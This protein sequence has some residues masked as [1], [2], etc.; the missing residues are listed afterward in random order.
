MEIEIQA[1]ICKYV[2]TNS[3]KHT[4]LLTDVPLG[5]GLSRGWNIHYLLHIFLCGLK[6]LLVSF[7]N[8]KKLYV[9]ENVDNKHSLGFALRIQGYH[10]LQLQSP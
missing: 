1:Q 9:Y 2:V 10:R 4:H 8:D 5:S 6:S 3:G 7:S